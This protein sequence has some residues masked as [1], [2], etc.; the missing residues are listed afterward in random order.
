MRN[1]VLELLE[2]IRPDVDFE[3]E[4]ELISQKIMESF[5]IIMMIS[6]LEEEFNV[7][8]SPKELVDENFNSVDAIVAMLERLQ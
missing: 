5:D 6:E 3:N 8:I 4:K 2:D 1:T 7:K